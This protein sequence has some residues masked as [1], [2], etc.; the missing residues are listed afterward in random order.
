MNKIIYKATSDPDKI[1]CIYDTLSGIVVV[2]DSK[3][4]AL[5]IAKSECGDE[6]EEPW[7]M[8][9]VE[10]IGTYLGNKKESHVVLMDFYNG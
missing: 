5:S 9:R 7:T 8:E 3:E 6:G 2:A 4:E 10:E 1:G